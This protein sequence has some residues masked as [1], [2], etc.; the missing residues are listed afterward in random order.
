MSSGTGHQAE[1][2]P[3]SAAP[4]SRLRANGLLLLAALIWGS[5]FVG[6]ALG[7][8]GV[9]PL[10]FTSV[11]FVLGALVVA[12]LAWREWQQLRSS[13]HAPGRAEARWV[14]LLGVLLCTGVVMQ[15]I[16][17]LSTSVTNAGFLTALYV[18][19]VPL[20]AWLF[21]RQLPHWSVWP[22]T[23]GCLAGT[24]LLT[25]ASAQAFSGGDLW[26]LLSALP[27]A[28]HVLLVGQVANKLRGAYLLAC[29]QFSICALASGLLGLA[30]EPVTLAGLR[31]AAGAIAYT[32]LLSVGVGFTLQV[33]GQRHAQPADAAI[34]L[35]SETVFAALFGAW[36]M[37]DRLNASGVMG[38]AL[39]LGCILL[40]QL[41]PLL[42]ARLGRPAQADASPPQ[43]QRHPG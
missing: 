42:R 6:Q 34:I 15:Q 3:V 29:G 14:A 43:A 23:A 38:C 19:L 33:I 7:M 40:V 35:S 24:W 10:T 37:G 22:A 26:V 2:P 32:G 41:L 18:P 12:P 17:L 28:V 30:T 20:L 31:S 8:A 39:I 27:W 4:M 36:F 13:G 16:G 9:G 25:G 11:R 21:Q 1:G 5:A